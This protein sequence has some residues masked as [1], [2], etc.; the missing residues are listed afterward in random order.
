MGAQELAV[1]QRAD[2][3]SSLVYEANARARDPVY[4]CVGAI[5]CLQ[6]Q[7][8]QLQMQL[9]M[10]QAEILYIQMQHQQTSSAAAET[11][12]V[13]DVTTEEES[14]FYLQNNYFSSHHQS[15]NFASTSN[16]NVIIQ[17][18]SLTFSV[19]GRK[20]REQG[21]VD[22]STLAC[23]TKILKYFLKNYLVSFLIP[24]HIIYIYIVMNRSV[25]FLTNL[26]FFFFFDIY[27]YI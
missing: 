25:S 6:T 22:E 13:A 10:A 8:S 7:V 2:A 1:D 24:I 5:S 4:G 19:W 18:Y 3:V 17:D 15:L 12:A 23:A 20:G 21:L 11:T 14:S 16:N 26:P 9:A 27:I